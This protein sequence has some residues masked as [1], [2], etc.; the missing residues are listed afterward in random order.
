MSTTE[1]T[2]E[3]GLYISIWGITYSLSVGDP[4][5]CKRIRYVAIF[6]YKLLD[7][8]HKVSASQHPSNH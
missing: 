2:A 8:L 4:S 6:H 3:N 7:T 5:L 1:A